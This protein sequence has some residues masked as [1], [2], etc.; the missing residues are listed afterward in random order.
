M[1]AFGRFRVSNPQTIFDS[2]LQYNLAPVQWETVTTSGGTAT[3][4]PNESSAR[5][6]VDTTSGASC[7]RQTYQYH[8]YQPGKSQMIAMTFVLG[9]A[10]T[11]VVKRVGYFDD[12]NGFYLK[13]D[14]AGAVVIG[15]RSYV[16]GSA[17]DTEI[18]QASWNL[19]V[20]DGSGPSGVTLD[21]DKSQQLVLDL[22][23]LSVG[24]VRAGFR[25]AGL[26][27]Y[28]HEF[29]LA[30]SLAT[31]YMTTANL[32]LRYE[33]VAT[34]V[35]GGTTDLIQ[36]CSK[37]ASEGGFESLLGL[38]VATGN[39]VTA[40]SVGTGLTCLVA[41]RPRLL[42]NGIANRAEVV[43]ES[44]SL[45]ITGAQN[46]YWE[47]LYKP[48]TLTGGAWASVD[49]TNSTVERNLT[50]TAIA[51]GLPIASGYVEAGNKV[52][53]VIDSLIAM[54]L[55]ITLDKAGTGQAEVAL[56]ARSFTGTTN[57]HGALAWR[58]QY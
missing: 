35:A 13:Q 24:R 16:T 12:E 3:H 44:L 48:T 56:A 5:L 52:A 34:G 42:F 4:L 31:A 32:P 43:L 36:I 41:I 39:A 33:I 22:E 30:N 40:V 53:S 26:V 23:W 9:S 17:V 27:I 19:D 7:I 45:F 57:S 2:Q 11:N 21:W 38:P 28:A 18:A 1:D 8:R 46:V 58:E 55:P 51:G 47:L 29:L 37:V 54:R 50:V 15:R 49:G 25:I 14:G 6:R 20:M 10:A